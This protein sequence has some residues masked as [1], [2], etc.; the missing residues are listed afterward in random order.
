M[1]FP[2]LK[3]SPRDRVPATDWLL[4]VVGA[5]AAA[6]IS[7]FYRDLSQRPGLPT[8]MDLVSAGI[9]MV[10]LLEATRRALG[11]A[12]TITALVFLTY[13]FFGNAAWVPNV[14][15]WQGASFAK[16]MRSEEHTSELQSLM[17]ISY[18]VFCLKNKIQITTLKTKHIHIRFK[19]N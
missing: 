4:A 3:R 16:A 8:T 1:V 2:A 12:L 9:G 5:L 19:R 11:P 18:A 15:Q 7:I 14:I 6:Y 10:L 13:V 17:R